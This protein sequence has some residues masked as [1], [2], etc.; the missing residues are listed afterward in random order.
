MEGPGVWAEALLEAGASVECVWVPR[1]GLPRSAV[2]ADLVISMGGSMSVNDPLPW[3]GDELVILRERID[4][5][6][7]TLG[8]CLGSQLI[9]RAAGGVV[10]PGPERSE[11]RRVGKECRSRWSPYH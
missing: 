2:G 1:R 7:P 8:V 9:A 4:A 6:A 11:E 10:E 5:G 3:I